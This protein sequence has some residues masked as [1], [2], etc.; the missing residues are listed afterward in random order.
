MEAGTGEEVNPRIREIEK[1]AKDE[2]YTF[3][4]D[5]D[6]DPDFS[7]LTIYGS[8][9]KSIPYEDLPQ[10][11]R[12]LADE[13]TQ[14]MHEDNVSTSGQETQNKAISAPITEKTT[15]VPPKTENAP[16]TIKTGENEVI[17]P[18][19]PKVEEKVAGEGEK[20]MTFGVKAL[21]SGK[22]GQDIKDGIAKEGINYVPRGRND[23]LS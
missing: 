19:P 14:L 20:E 16:E 7:S 4:A 17:P 3:E 5:A 11:I 23:G 21:S 12:D 15:E 13:Y 10:G 1:I 2:G 18:E 6:L 22:L 9:K 8:D